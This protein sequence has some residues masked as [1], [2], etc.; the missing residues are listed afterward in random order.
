[1]F[2]DTEIGLML[3]HRRQMAS[4]EQDAQAIVDGQDATIARLQRQLAATQRQNSDLVLSR[5][6]ARNEVLA[7]RLADGH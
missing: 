3:R 7:R 4:F 1:M 2:T 6:Q 5:G